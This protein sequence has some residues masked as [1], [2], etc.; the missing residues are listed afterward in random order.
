[1]AADHALCLLEESE[2]WPLAEWWP[3]SAGFAVGIFSTA[4]LCPVP[5]RALTFLE[6]WKLASLATIPVFLITAA[7]VY[8]ACRVIDSPLGGGRNAADIAVGTGC[9]AS[10]FPAVV[11]FYRYNSPW[12]AALTMA[13]AAVGTRSLLLRRA[14]GDA[15]DQGRLPPTA[16]AAALE[17]GAAVILAGDWRGAAIALPVAAVLTTWLLTSRNVWPLNRARPI[18]LRVV[19]AFM[20]GLVFSAGGLTPYLAPGEGAGGLAAMLRSLFSGGVP[21]YANQGET[22]E[23][24]ELHAPFGQQVQP[25]EIG[26]SYPAVM[27]WPEVERYTLLVAPPPAPRSAL[28]TAGPPLSTGIPFSGF[29]SFQ[30]ATVRPPRQWHVTRGDTAVST[31][32]T[33]D[34]SPLVMEAHQDFGRPIDMRCCREIRLAFRVEEPR[35]DTVKVELVLSDRRAPDG[36][37]ASLGREPL[38]ATVVFRI[39][40]ASALREFDHATV[41]FHLAVPRWD[42]SPKMALRRFHFT[43]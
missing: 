20:L 14:P 1:M 5:V 2:P 27:L 40:S 3:V 10:W 38:A 11:L 24:A 26:E 7:A 18:K 22:P 6:I 39:P 42:R 32:R 34:R 37:S 35:P 4:L 33:T 9:A 41:R 13:L 16:T 12:A 23:A 43:P 19:P 17:F 28:L 36:P 21:G 8:M 15:A 29:Y 30:R 31:F 25:V